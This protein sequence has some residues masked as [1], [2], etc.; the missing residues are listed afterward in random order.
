[1]KSPMLNPDSNPQRILLTGN[2]NSLTLH[3]ETYQDPTGPHQLE[4]RHPLLLWS[5][6]GRTQLAAP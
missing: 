3:S 1:M 2:N 6:G 4:Q 5:L